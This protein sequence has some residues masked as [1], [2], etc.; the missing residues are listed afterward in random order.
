MLIYKAYK[1][2]TFEQAA[3]SAA[4]CRCAFFIHDG[5]LYEVTIEHGGIER[6]SIIDTE[7]S[8]VGSRCWDEL[9]EVLKKMPEEEL[10]RL[11]MTN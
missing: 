11:K 5:I 3:R 4:S 7:G 2:S 8:P 1:D 6:G 9:P 10:E